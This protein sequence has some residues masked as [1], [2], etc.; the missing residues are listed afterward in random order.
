[1]KAPPSRPRHPPRQTA[2]ALLA[3]S[4]LPLWRR[5][6]HEFAAHMHRWD[7]PPN[8]AHT[9][10]HLHVAPGA[11]EPAELAKT[12]CLPR[13][14]VTFIL[15]TLE[16]E[17]KG[18]ESPT[19]AEGLAGFVQ[20][21][22]DLSCVQAA[23]A[24]GEVAKICA[25]LVYGYHAKGATCASPDAALKTFAELR[26][27]LECSLAGAR[28]AKDRAGETAAQVMIPEALDYPL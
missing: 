1:M 27:G 8:A 18:P 25:E 3:A 28:L 9:L 21:Y 20:F 7:L 6:G 19:L 16:L 5:I 11:C 10:L 26:A 15:D 24:A 22:S 12:V 2:E 4:M 23:R 17:K 13:Q 14:T